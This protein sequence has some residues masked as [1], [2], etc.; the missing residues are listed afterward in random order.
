[1]KYLVLILLC[2]PTI[3]YSNCKSDITVSFVSQYKVNITSTKEI[4]HIV[5][6]DTLKIE[7]SS[8]QPYQLN[9][10]YN[11]PIT[12]VTVKSGCTRY[13]QNN[14]ILPVTLIEYYIQD[15]MLYWTTTT[16]INNSHFELQY[17]QDSF[18][19]IQY[20]QGNGTTII[21]H[22]YS[23]QLTQPGYYRIIQVDYDNTKTYYDILP[24]YHST[25]QPS[26]Q[27]TYDILGR[28]LK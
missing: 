6:N 23:T 3:L 15:S 17:L 13:T 22:T 28:Q 19:S 2:I 21:Q 4:S 25:I 24:Y 10:Q 7:Y 8:N 20:I 11:F 9:L 1:M 27:P 26:S 16:E 14:P 12:T 18:V 5:V